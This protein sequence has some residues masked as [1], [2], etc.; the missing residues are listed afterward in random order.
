MMENKYNVETAFDG[1]EAGKKFAAFQPDLMF[2][3]I[4][5]PALD[6]FQVYAN[7]RNDQSN[8][9]TKIVIISGVTDLEEIEKIKQLGADGY[10]QKPFS[11]ESLKEEIKRVL[12]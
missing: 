12:G 2:L 5:M 6:G 10:L 1:F 3:D 11:N 7:I 4:H 9:H 8:K